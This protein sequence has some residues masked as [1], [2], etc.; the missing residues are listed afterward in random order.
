MEEPKLSCAFVTRKELEE[1]GYDF[2]VSTI[3]YIDRRAPHLIWK[4]FEEMGI[5]YVEATKQ[6]M[7]V[8][9][10]KDKFLNLEQ[11]DLN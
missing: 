3:N 4:I 10:S 6:Y 1:L 7:I 5:C 8:D 11:V 9:L 2:N